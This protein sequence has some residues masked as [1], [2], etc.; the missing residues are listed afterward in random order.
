MSLPALK[1]V[2]AGGFGTGKTTLVGSV[3]EIPPLSTEALMT[4][5][6][7]DV[8]DLAGLEHKTRTTVALDFGRRTLTDPHVALHLFGVPGQARFWFT[9][10]DL[11]R[12]AIGAV[13]MVDTRRL[14]TSFDAVDFFERC[15]MPY[16]VAVNQFEGSGWYEL[17]QIR[18]A[19]EIDT[20]VPLV[21]CD[22]RDPASSADV[23]IALLR[24]KARITAAQAPPPP[25]TTGALL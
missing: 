3:S 6:S 17:D 12:G 19:L 24:H 18:E 11:S 22:A 9:W 4:E 10:P 7:E 13:V 2:I 21:R 16:I 14:D 23:L 15:D 8:D 5:A 1:M 25:P 20:S